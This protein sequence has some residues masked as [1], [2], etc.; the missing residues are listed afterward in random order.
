MGDGNPHQ[1]ILHQQAGDT[2]H[3]AGDGTVCTVGEGEEVSVTVSA[4]V[5]GGAWF[6]GGFGVS[7]TVTKSTSKGCE[8]DGGDAGGG[9]HRNVYQWVRMHHTAYTAVASDNQL[10]NGQLALRDEQEPAVVRSPNTGGNAVQFYCV[11]DTCR[12]IGASYWQLGR[13]RGPGVAGGD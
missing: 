3:C 6:T 5:G 10:C 12:F 8:A 2:Q 11:V 7:Q 9:G 4:E 1:D 13:P